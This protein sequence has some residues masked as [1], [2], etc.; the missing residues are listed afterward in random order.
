MEISLSDPI[1]SQAVKH[2]KEKH[3]ISDPFDYVILQKLFEEEFHCK[4][5]I[6]DPL[7]LEG[8]LRIDEAKYYNW[9]LLKFGA[10]KNE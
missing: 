6:T 2:V 4:V 3:S 7:A 1:I 5:I 8:I 10:P 9:F